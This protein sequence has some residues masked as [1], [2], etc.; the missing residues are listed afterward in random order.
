[1]VIPTAR[2]ALDFA[3]LNTDRGVLLTDEMVD[4]EANKVMKDWMSIPNDTHPISQEFEENPELWKKL[5]HGHYVPPESNIPIDLLQQVMNA[6]AL[7]VQNPTVTHCNAA[8]FHI[9]RIQQCPT[10]AYKG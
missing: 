7:K 4:Q 8:A 2:S 6:C 3:A 1:M 10:Q 5:L 9:C